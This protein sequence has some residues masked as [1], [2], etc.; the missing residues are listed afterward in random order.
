MFFARIL[1]FVAS[2]ALSKG[3]RDSGPSPFLHFALIMIFQ[4]VFGFL[5]M[6]VVSY[7]SRIREYAADKGSAQLVGKHKMVAALEGL[8]ANIGLR[9]MPEEQDALATLK[10]SAKRSKFLALLST[11][12]DLNDRIARLQAARS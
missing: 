8:K 7:F 11:H 10:I 5:G 4:M 6:I 3:D 2:Q 1:A 12:P 9:E